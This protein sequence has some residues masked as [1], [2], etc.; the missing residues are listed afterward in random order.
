MQRVGVAS[1]RATVSSARSAQGQLRSPVRLRTN[2]VAVADMCI[3]VQ[4]RSLNVALKT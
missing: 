3:A 1:V 2:G 4:E